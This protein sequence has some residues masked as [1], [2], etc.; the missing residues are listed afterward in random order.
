MF[1]IYMGGFGVDFCV[2]WVRDGSCGCF[3]GCG[4]SSSYY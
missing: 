4:K 2:I 3:Q 1:N